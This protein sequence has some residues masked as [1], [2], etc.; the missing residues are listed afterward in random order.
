MNQR[1]ILYALPLA[2]AAFVA[3]ADDASVT[4]E[5][6]NGIP[7]GPLE[8][9]SIDAPR[10]SAAP[11]RL[12]VDQWRASFPVIFGSDSKG[13]PITWNL[14][15]NKPALEGSIA[16]SLGEPDYIV[17]TDEALE[18]SLL[19]AKFADD[20]ARSLC[21]QVLDADDVRTDPN[22]RV[23]LRFAS[24]EDSVASNAAAIDANLRY[25]KLR[26]HGIYVPKEDTAATEPLRNLFAA[27]A[28]AS[29]APEPIQKTRDAWKVV[30]VALVTAPE[31]HVY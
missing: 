25:L 15:G 10:A 18:P 8:H 19:Y 16:A 28:L 20:A 12:S 7:T 13:R 24:K 31:F 3:C 14:D 9:P 23:L 6:G 30:C 2:F 11:R 26:F 29:T 5:V 27:A 22:T 1:S 4:V 17:N 21:T